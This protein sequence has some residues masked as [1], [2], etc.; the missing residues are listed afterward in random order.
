MFEGDRL[1]VHLSVLSERQSPYLK[2]LSLFSDAEASSWVWQTASGEKRW[3]VWPR[4]LTCSV[5]AEAM[6]FM[7]SCRWGFDLLYLRFQEVCLPGCSFSSPH[8]QKGQTTNPQLHLARKMSGYGK[9]LHAVWRVWWSEIITKKNFSFCWFFHLCQHYTHLNDF[10]WQCC[11]RIKTTN[12]LFKW[13]KPYF[14]ELKPTWTCEKCW[15]KIFHHGKSEQWM[16]PNFMLQA[17]PVQA[18]A[19]VCSVIIS[20]K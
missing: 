6:Y 4:H 11:N 20:G 9:Y 19:G 18:G 7:N 1:S 8:V 5:M 3:T 13:S 17:K 15:C 10:Q 12:S 14:L 16:C 2:W